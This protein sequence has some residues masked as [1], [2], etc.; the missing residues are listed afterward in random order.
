MAGPAVLGVDEFALRRGD[1]YGTLLVDVQA[2]RPIDILPDRSADSF[3]AWLAA[4]PG[5]QLSA[6][7]GRAAMP[8]A[9][10]AVHRKLFRSRIA[11]ICG[12]TSAM[13]WNG[14]WPGTGAA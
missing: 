7:T 5:T 4:H 10:P 14:R 13:R 2:H 8:M 1:S 6:G 9:R 11:G 12:T 3:A